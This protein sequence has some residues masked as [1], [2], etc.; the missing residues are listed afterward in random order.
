MPKNKQKN[1]LAILL[2]GLF[3]LFLFFGGPVFI[4]IF[5]FG[6]AILKK[7]KKQDLQKISKDY[8]NIDL[9]V[10]NL[11]ALRKINQKNIH[12]KYETTVNTNKDFGVIANKVFSAFLFN[13]SKKLN[14]RN[15]YLQ[16]A[17]N[18]T[19]SEARKIVASLPQSDKIIIEAGTPLIKTE[20]INVVSDLRAIAPNAYI[21]ADIKV[22][23][24]AEKEV[25]MVAQTGAE[26]ATCLGVAPIETI[27]KFIQA[28]IE[29][30]IDSMIDLMNVSDPVS[31]FR[32]LKKLPLVAIIHRG[33]DETEATKDKAIPYYQINKIKGAYNI[34]VAVAGGDDNREVESAIFNGADI[35]VVW[36]NFMQSGNK[37]TE[38]ANLFLKNIK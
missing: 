37:I 33:V 31:L 22:S 3:F 28:C 5:M 8:F 20:G 18:S 25:A 7:Y 4:I 34:M 29:N 21:V 24:N 2:M 11:T 30:K 6:I 27:D 17:L 9:E 23:D 32:K 36:K 15:K 16:I 14:K 38:M 10:L 12:P 26:A 35:V 13:K 19:F 1:N